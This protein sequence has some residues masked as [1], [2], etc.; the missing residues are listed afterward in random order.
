VILKIKKDVTY[1]I[2]GSKFI[3][4]KHFS[5]YCV[6]VFFL[7]KYHYIIYF[8]DCSNA[9]HFFLQVKSYYGISRNLLIK[10]KDDQIDETSILAQ[11]LSS[12]SAIS[13]LLDMSI[14]SL[15]GDHGLPLQQVLPDVPPAMADAV[16]RGGELLTNL[17]TGTPW[18]AVAKEVGSTLGADSGVLRAQISKDVNTLVDVIVSWIE[19]NSGPRLLRS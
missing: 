7:K 9:L 6:V 13:S 4:M 5:N 16:N 11:V 14:R 12:E 15:P 17:A 10:F 2:N 3:I 1:V 19:S 8:Y 18:E